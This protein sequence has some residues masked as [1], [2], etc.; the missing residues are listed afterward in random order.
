MHYTAGILGS[1]PALPLLRTLACPAAC[2]KLLTPNPRTVVSILASLP[3]NRIEKHAQ[4]NGYMYIYVKSPAVND[5]F[6]LL[7]S[8]PT[9][10]PSPD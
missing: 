6:A 3:L 5:V 8:L 2:S 7:A 9:P 1:P 4:M 10:E